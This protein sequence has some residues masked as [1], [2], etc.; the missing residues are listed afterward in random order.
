VPL[1]CEAGSFGL[2][3]LETRDVLVANPVSPRTSIFSIS[4]G[5]FVFFS[6][7]FPVHYSLIYFKMYYL[8]S[9]S[10]C[11]EAYCFFENEK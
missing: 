7:A 5:L 2:N 8:K 10:V 6:A 3:V 9:V 4:T 1:E 11:S